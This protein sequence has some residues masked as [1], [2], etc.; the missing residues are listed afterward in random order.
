[1]REDTLKSADYVIVGAGS[2]GCVLANRLS[3]DGRYKVLVIEAG[4]RDRNLLFSIPLAARWLWFDQ[5][6]NWNYQ[7]ELEPGLDGRTVQVPRGKVLGG[8]S[9]INGMIYARGHS[10]DYDQWRQ[11]GLSGWGYEDVLP[12]FKR[13]ETN[14]RGET[15]HHGA[16]G[17]LK[18]PTYPSKN[19]GLEKI[20]KAAEVAGFNSTDDFHGP[21]QEGFGAPDMTASGRFRSSTARTYLRPALKRSNLE[22]IT[23][24]MAEGLYYE[25]GWATGVKFRLDGRTHLAR[26]RKEVILSGGAINSP[27]LLML[28]GIGDGMTLREYG[29]SVVCE[30]KG[31]GKNLQDHLAVGVRHKTLP[32]LS[33]ER[34]LRLD[35]LG[36]QEGE[37]QQDV[38]REVE[39]GEEVGLQRPELAVRLGQVR[40]QRGEPV[41]AGEYDTW[42]SNEPDSI[43]C[44]TVSRAASTPSRSVS[45]NRPTSQSMRT[46]ARDPAMSSRNMRWSNG[47]LSFSACSASDGPPANRPCHSVELTTDSVCERG[48]VTGAH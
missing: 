46:C 17:P 35:R 32:D 47:R 19:I 21:D 41:G 24:A 43:S 16:N 2:A 23:G 45:V 29:I 36:L 37:V 25:D 3:A 11:T 31:V 15:D 38:P 1:M 10:G 20:V 12:Y 13:A 30:R 18:V 34:Q 22:V 28:S 7:S 4:Q 27:H 39:H 40:L 5:R 33:F 44:S 14:P 42:K 9:S 8:S 6:Y 48:S 26:A